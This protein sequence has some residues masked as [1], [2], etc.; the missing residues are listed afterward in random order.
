MSRRAYQEG[1]CWG[2]GRSMGCTDPIATGGVPSP[3]FPD[4][5][6]PDDA[7]HTLG[8]EAMVEPISPAG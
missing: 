3:E 7:P 2:L 4:R 1:T 6:L 5:P 8:G